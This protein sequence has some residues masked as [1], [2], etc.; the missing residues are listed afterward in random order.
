MASWDVHRAAITPSSFAAAGE[1]DD[2]RFKFAAHDATL[3]AILR[4]TRRQL[5]DYKVP[6]RLWAVDAVPRNSLGKVDRR[7]AA[8]TAML[9]RVA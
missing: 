3:G 7:S 9:G 2:Q 5:A 6:E 1:E 4:D 8:A